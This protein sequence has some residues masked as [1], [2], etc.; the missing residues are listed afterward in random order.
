MSAR[1]DDLGAGFDLAFHEEC[2]SA[3]HARPLPRV[4]VRESVPSTDAVVYWDLPGQGEPCGLPAHPAFGWN[5]CGRRGADGHAIPYLVTCDSR[6]CP[7]CWRKGW[8]QREASRCAAVLSAERKARQACG[9][10]WR[11]VHASV[12]PPRSLWH[13]ADTQRG[14]R[15]LRSRAYRVARKAGVE[16]GC[17]V[18]HRVRCADKDDPT[19]TD[20]PHFHVLGFGWIADGS[21]T[22]K[23]TGWIVKNH[24]VR[25]GTAA[26][27][28]TARYVL[29]HSHRAEGNLLEGKSGGSTLTVTWFGRT[30]SVSEIHGEGRF[31]PLCEVSYPLC[32]WTRLEW[33]GQ[34]PPPTEPCAWVRSDW[35]VVR[36]P[37]GWPC[38]DPLAEFQRREDKSWMGGG[39]PTGPRRQAVDFPEVPVAAR[40]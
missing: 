18:F 33:A 31:C 34:G 9:K 13:L 16:G 7:T 21:Q 37:G 29:S 39:L 5:G 22:F 15:Q 20:G 28:G 36:P 2:D 10:R 11:V 27:M 25:L 26:I 35:R 1:P 6:S 24:G 3:A 32:E 38:D 19:E 8:L 40:V 23:R 30:V 14:F 4:S 12:N 17:A